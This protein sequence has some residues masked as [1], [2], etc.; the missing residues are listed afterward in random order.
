MPPYPWQRGLW[1]QFVGWVERERLA[2]ALLIS[3]PT[4]LGGLAL[5][6][7]MGQYLLCNAP[8]GPLACGKCRGCQLFASETHPD[9]FVVQPEGTASVIKV[10]QVRELT[11]FISKTAQQGGRKVVML[12]PAEAMN[13]SAA[14]ALLKSLEEPTANTFLLLVSPESSR[15][16]ATI[17]SRCAKMH[18][19]PPKPEQALD[20][21]AKVG[22]TDAAAQLLAEAGGEPLKVQRWFEEDFPAHR[23]RMSQDLGAIA[24]GQRS[25]LAVAKAWLEKDLIEIIDCMMVWVQAA[26]KQRESRAPTEYGDFDVI[27]QVAGAP[28]PLLFRYLDKLAQSK[29]ELQSQSNPNQELLLDELLMGWASMASRSASRGR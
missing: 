20:W 5:A 18:L 23:Q 29:K 25:P 3:G 24:S 16:L 26:V 6:R 27:S 9:F 7:A 10:D 17:R 13:M 19:T 21:L 15:L 1:E 14:N 28:T 11:G 8:T 22:V 4:G 12:T 2:H